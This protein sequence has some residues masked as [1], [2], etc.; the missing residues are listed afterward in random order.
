MSFLEFL[1]NL[2]PTID[3]NY[4]SEEVA[5][6]VFSKVDRDG[7]ERI[8]LEEL[9]RAILLDN[10]VTPKQIQH[11]KESIMG[12]TRATDQQIQLI[13]EDITSGK[14]FTFPQLSKFM[15]TTD[16]GATALQID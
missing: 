2:L 9:E 12:G 4:D 6:R 15:R 1:K 13:F 11:M 10:A 7:D 5:E 8:S 3:L 14:E 16:Q